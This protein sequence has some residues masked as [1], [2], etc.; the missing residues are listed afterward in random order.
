TRRDWSSDVCSSDL[1]KEPWPDFL[2]FYATPAT[3]AAWIVPKK[4]VEQVGDEGFKKHPIGA[5]PYKFVSHTPGVEVVREAY[6]AYWRKVPS[7]K[8]LVIKSVPDGTTRV[9]MLKKGEAD[10]AAALDGP[11][12]EDVRRD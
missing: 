3:G 5:G 6:P 2:T 11:E 9:A 8:R 1:L 4:Y 10:V 7:I 12:G